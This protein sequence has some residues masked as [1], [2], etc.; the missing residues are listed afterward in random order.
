MLNLERQGRAHNCLE[1]VEREGS[2]K[3]FVILAKPLILTGNPLNE[4]ENE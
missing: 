1:Y 2:G 4:F 3:V